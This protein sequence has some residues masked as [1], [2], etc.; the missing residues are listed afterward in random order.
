MTVT[1]AGDFTVTCTTTAPP[2]PGNAGQ[3]ALSSGTLALQVSTS[4]STLVVTRSG[5]TTDAISVPYS[6]TSGATPCCNTSSG[7]LNFATAS[8]TSQP[9][10]VTATTTVGTCTVTIT[11]PTT[12][13]TATASTAPSLGSPA[14]ATVTVTAAPP[15]PP[16][17][18]CPTP[19]ANMVT[20]A[21]SQATD[22]GPQ[23]T[24][25][26][27][28]MLHQQIGSFRLPDGTVL[29]G[30]SAKMKIGE[31]TGTVLGSYL[32]LTISKCP[33][34]IDPS[35]P[36]ACYWATS[37]PNY[38]ELLWF[39]QLGPYALTTLQ[40]HNFCY[41]PRLDATG[42]PQQWYLN[43][44]WTYPHSAWGIGRYGFTWGSAGY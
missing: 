34:V 23:G 21:D 32:E 2:A 9:I 8:S 6:I 20:H 5:G 39:Y 36:P 33:G 15:P 4:S 7:A 13:G 25:T 27:L 38:N 16:P 43:A 35:A 44:P 31:T 12:V 3:F 29:A 41:A 30:N 14:S 11:A 1:P 10:A 28:T 18:S 40:S 22:F 19:P 42:A 26:T 17:G 37:C 24:R